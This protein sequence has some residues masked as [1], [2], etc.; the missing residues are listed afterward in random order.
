MQESKDKG[1]ESSRNFREQV[2]EEIRSNL[3]DIINKAQLTR[4]ADLGN[5]VSRYVDVKHNPLVAFGFYELFI[6]N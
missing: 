1:T 4:K 3:W 2:K 5:I 6:V